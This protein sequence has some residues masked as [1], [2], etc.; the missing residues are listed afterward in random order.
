MKF[1][2]LA[3]LFSTIARGVEYHVD[4]TDAKNLVPYDAARGYGFVNGTEKSDVKL[5]NVK[6]E[7]GNYEVTVKFGN[8]KAAGDT[9]LKTENRRL[10]VNHLETA[11][12][13][14]EAR[15]F[16]VNVRNQKISGGGMTKLNGR[17]M[18]PP[19]SASW[20][21]LLSLE[22]NGTKPAVASIDIKP[23]KNITTVFI[24]GDSTVT[25]Q[26]K[27]PWA[28]WGQMLP[29]FFDA[30]VAVS[31]QAESGL[32]LFSFKGQN[33]LDKVF[34]MMKK[35][36]YLFIQFG[37]N[38]QK[39]KRPGAGPFTTYKADLKSYVEA[40]RKK[41]GIPILVS[42]MERRRFQGDKL[43]PTLAQYAEA[44]KQV[45]QEE[46]VP[47]IDLN[48]M[49]IKFYEALGAKNS[50][51]A[52]VHYPA[53]TFPGQAKALADDTHHN[54]FGAYELARCIVEGIKKN[55]PEL[56]KHL[57]KNAGTFDPAKPDS[58]AKLII[59]A[60]PFAVDTEKPAGN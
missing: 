38:D 37:H 35:G 41:G 44:V 58:P 56:A 32:A 24:A 33:R 27:E 23:V 21:D 51:K 8:P 40:T 28:G 7:E 4:L 48:A 50:V 5:F 20:D 29:A 13:K 36:D 30:N 9:T 6:A 46:K 60:S 49:S 10:L 34:S 45:G 54:T 55:V 19:I 39:D 16:I 42:S 11:A 43:M 52:L 26:G 17:E 59:P 22:I 47:V 31:N 25:D 53:N 15:K 14:Y 1:L 3:M 18:G 2:L 57:D 12:G